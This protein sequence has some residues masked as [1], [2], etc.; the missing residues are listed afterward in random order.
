MYRIYGF[1]YGESNPELQH[2]GRTTHVPWEAGMKVQGT[3][4]CSLSPPQ[5]FDEKVQKEHLH[6]LIV[7]IRIRGIEPRAAARRAYSEYM[8]G[9]NVSRY[10]ISEVSSNSKPLPPPGTTDL[11]WFASP[12]ADNALVRWNECGD[13]TADAGGSATATAIALEASGKT[14]TPILWTMTMTLPFPPLPL[15][16][17]TA[18]FFDTAGARVITTVLAR[19]SS[20]SPARASTFLRATRP[21]APVYVPKSTSSASTAVVG[22]CASVVTVTAET[23]RFWLARLCRQCI[24]CRRWLFECERILGYLYAAS[25][26]ASGVVSSS[27]STANPFVEH[28]ACDRIWCLGH[29]GVIYYHPASSSA[30][31]SLATPIHIRAGEDSKLL[32]RAL[33]RRVSVASWLPSPVRALLFRP[34]RLCPLH[35]LIGVSIFYFSPKHNK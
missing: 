32:H 18:S 15:H 8:R 13:T 6:E 31:S 9:G 7:L 20:S 26:L 5:Y 2:E 24:D 19:P 17:P 23:T 16:P 28:S 35:H 34:V 27:S 21:S 11:A 25:S 30:A 29:F 12:N 4:Y 33:P 22:S 3:W 1:G 10:T 14:M